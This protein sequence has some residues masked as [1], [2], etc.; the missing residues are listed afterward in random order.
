MSTETHVNRA[1]DLFDTQKGSLL[2]RLS[3]V[4]GQLKHVLYE[5]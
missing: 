3:R 4:Q 5:W 1:T 2:R